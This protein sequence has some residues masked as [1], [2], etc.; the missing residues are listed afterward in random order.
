MHGVKTKSWGKYALQNRGDRVHICML[1]KDASEVIISVLCHELAL[2]V[3][4]PLSQQWMV[5]RLIPLDPPRIPT[6]RSCNTSA[7]TSG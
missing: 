7:L 6:N 4:Y 2:D 1:G 5:N 3:R